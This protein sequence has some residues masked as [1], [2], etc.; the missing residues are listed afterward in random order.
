MSKLEDLINGS[1][2][3]PIQ[4][5]ISL[6]FI[7]RAKESEDNRRTDREIIEKLTRKVKDVVLSTEEVKIYT[8]YGD[9]EWDIKYPFRSIYFKDEKWQR[10]NTVS[11]TL[12]VAFL[13]YLE[14]KHLDANSRFTD[15]AL[16]MLGIKIEE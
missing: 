11:P 8:V 12:G 4:K 13:N 2:M 3:S 5:N 1:D 15:F 10:V 6:G 16:K 7:S 14:Y 9:S